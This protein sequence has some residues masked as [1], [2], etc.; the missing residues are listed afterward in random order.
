MCRFFWWLCVFLNIWQ[1]CYLENYIRKCD[2]L[3]SL[4][5]CDVKWLQGKKLFIYFIWWLQYLVLSFAETVFVIVMTGKCMDGIFLYVLD[6]V[7]CFL[8]FFV[9]DGNVQEVALKARSVEFLWWMWMTSILLNELCMACCGAQFLRCSHPLWEA[10]LEV[11]T[12]RLKYVA[13]ASNF[14]SMI[15]ARVFLT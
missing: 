12:R 11:G 10:S 14:L 9:A 5:T 7:W 15:S 8:I 2:D 1:H 6:K 4:N 13:A 3:G